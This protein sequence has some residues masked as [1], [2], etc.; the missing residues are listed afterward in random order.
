MGAQLSSTPPIIRMSPGVDR[1]RPASGLLHEESVQTSIGAE[2]REAPPS[3]CPAK[4]HR[5][6]RWC[7]T[8]TPT[9]MLRKK[10]S[11]M[12]NWNMG[13]ASVRPPRRNIWAVTGGSEAGV[14]RI[15]RRTAGSSAI[16]GRSFAATV[17]EAEVEGEVEGGVDG[18]VE[19][20]VEVAV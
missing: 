1:S 12:E 4:D 3:A 10:G 6:S 11:P 2:S 14:P 5:S 19:A 18:E 15:A 8:R 13:C 20:E 16:A 9:R 7:S 17:P